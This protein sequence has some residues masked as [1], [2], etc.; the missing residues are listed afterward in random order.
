M[1]LSA[2]STY[3]SIAELGFFDKD[4]QLLI[5]EPIA[6]REASLDTIP[7]AFDNKW[8]TNFEVD[9][10]PNGNWVGM[11]FHK[12]Q[13]VASVR[14]IPRSDDN[15]IHP[16]QKYE[17]KYLSSRGIWKTLGRKTATG[18]VLEYDNVPASCLLWLR[19]HTSGTEE[20]P[21]IYNGPQDIVW[22]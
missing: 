1:N 9:W 16:G 12:P 14:I 22:W 4:G 18:N 7:L 3:G 10:N 21:F 19:N 15:D 8:L 13:A 6:N 11:D 20:R 2:D 17:L 5:G